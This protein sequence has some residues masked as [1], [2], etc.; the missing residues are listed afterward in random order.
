MASTREQL[1]SAIE[2]GDADAARALLAADPSLATERDGEGV[3]TLMR[4]VYRGDASM[5]EALRAGRPELDVFEAS[6]LGDVGRLSELLSDDPSI[7]D[8][9]SPDGFT[10]L[11]LAAFFG[12]SEAVRLLIA[13]GAEVDPRGSG[14]MT[15][16]PLHSAAASGHTDIGILLLDAGADPDARQSGGWTP[17]H[18]AAQ[19]RDA[20]LV[21]E[22]LQR[23]ADP[24]AINDDGRSVRDLAEDGGDPDVIARI[25]EALVRR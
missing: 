12:E 1:F 20:S 23:G 14:W 24:A 5:V 11:H 19:N 15:G 21:E 25:E 7:A 8:A 3:S 4:A 13:R 6:A 9:R 22:L 18:S 17:L 16:T 2:E 10:V